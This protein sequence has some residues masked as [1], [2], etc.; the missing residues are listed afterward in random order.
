MKKKAQRAVGLILI[1]AL[2]ATMI[3]FTSAAG[4]KRYTTSSSRS[5]KVTCTLINKRNPGYVH[6]LMSNASYNGCT[7]RNT[8]SMYTTSGGYIWSE[9]GAIAMDG[10]RTFYLGADHSAYC[11]YI[12]P[13]YGSASVYMSN[14]GNVS[15]S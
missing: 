8:V 6:V 9:R 11:I 1:L 13:Y 5:T 10:S 3:P 14:Y 12:T 2:V 4:S 7:Q 15:I